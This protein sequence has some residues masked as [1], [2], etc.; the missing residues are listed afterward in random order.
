MRIGVKRI[1]TG[2]AGGGIQRRQNLPDKRCDRDG[3]VRMGRLGRQPEEIAVETGQRPVV[4]HRRV[5]LPLA[6][7]PV[8]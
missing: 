5:L 6:L 2:A 4:S 8:I 1:P 7:A 3:F